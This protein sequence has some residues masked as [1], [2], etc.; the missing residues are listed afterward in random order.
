[1]FEKLYHLCS[2]QKRRIS[3]GKVNRLRTFER[4]RFS[5]C[6]MIAQAT[7]PKRFRS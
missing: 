2:T 7:K 1:M 5:S 6:P 4:V 3:A